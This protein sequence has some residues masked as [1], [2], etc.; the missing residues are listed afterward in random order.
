MMKTSE[1]MKLAMFFMFMGALILSVLFVRRPSPAKLRCRSQERSSPAPSL[2]AS[3]SISKLSND[4]LDQLRY[5]SLRLINNDRKDHGLPPVV[6][7]TNAA[8]QL[9]AEDM[10]IHDYFGH[11]WADGRKPYMVYS[12]IG[13]ASY[14][15]ENVA[16]SGWTDHEWIARQC[17]YERCTVPM[18]ME[19]IT[20]H[21]WGMMY[22]D[23][24]ANWGHR[25]NILG[26]THR[27]VNI[28]IGFNGRRM[29]YV[30]HFEGGAVQ[31]NGGP[32]LNQNGELC[33]SL[34]KQETGIT[35]GAVSIAYDPPP[36]P[37]TPAQIG[38]LNRYCVGGGFTARCPDFS[39]AEIL[40]PPPPGSYYPNLN[41]N[42]VVASRWIDDYSHFTMTA[43]MGSLFNKPGVYT[44]TVWRD[45]REDYFS[46]QLVVLSLFVE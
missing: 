34:N 40:K 10:L 31:A 37:K 14:V 17:N 18:P 19:E 36:T 28:G 32:V 46:E 2:S 16:T 41:T 43:K 27:A 33:L 15:S 38:A 6:L 5:H 3:P 7:G 23:A 24:H 21:Q 35:I 29:T 12:Q 42:E 45:D 1:R 20:D 39:A 26:K 44:V 25:D 13:G 11:W 30:Q 4:K 8:A 22:D 9:H